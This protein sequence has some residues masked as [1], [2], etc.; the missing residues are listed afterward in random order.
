MEICMQKI[1]CFRDCTLYFLITFYRLVRFK[2]FL[3]CSLVLIISTKLIWQKKKILD[4]LGI[5]NGLLPLSL[6]QLGLSL[7]FEY[8]SWPYDVFLAGLKLLSIFWQF[9]MAARQRGWNEMKMIISLSLSAWVR[10]VVRATYRTAATYTYVDGC[11]Y[12]Y[13]R[14]VFMCAWLWF[15]LPCHTQILTHT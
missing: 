5:D 1:C 7:N 13:M 14:L 9:H 4:V 6:H 2:Q 8:N 15:H 11:G 12:M 3:A 10:W